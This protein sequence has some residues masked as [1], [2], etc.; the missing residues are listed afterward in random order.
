[1]STD[2]KGAADHLLCGTAGTAAP[3]PELLLRSDGASA[4]QNGTAVLVNTR[5]GAQ[6][7]GLLYSLTTH[8]C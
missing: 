2:Q 4:P 7:D 5:T 1:M 3:C 8:F 6:P